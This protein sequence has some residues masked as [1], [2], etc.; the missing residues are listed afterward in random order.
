MK[1]NTRAPKKA[2][3][4]VSLPQPNLQPAFLGRARERNAPTAFLGRE[5][6]RERDAPTAF[7]WQMWDAPRR[8]LSHPTNYKPDSS[9]AC[10][11]KSLILKISAH[12]FK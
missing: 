2:P 3:C 7:F 12:S 8:H 6:A 9:K 4:W 10:I 5:R 1:P 11:N